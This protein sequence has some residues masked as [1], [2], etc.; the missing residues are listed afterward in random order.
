VG[1]FFVFVPKAI[2]EAMPHDWE[3]GWNAVEALER[4]KWVEVNDYDNDDDSFR[5]VSVLKIQKVERFGLPVTLETWPRVFAF[6]RNIYMEAKNIKEAF[7]TAKKEV[8]GT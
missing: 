8:K 7:H 3:L 6:I 2:L 4:D 1:N 5:V